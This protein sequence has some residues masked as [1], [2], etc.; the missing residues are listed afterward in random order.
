MMNALIESE[1]DAARS[2]RAIGGYL[3]RLIGQGPLFW[4]FCRYIIL[5]VPERGMKR[6]AMLWLAYE[7]GYPLDGLSL[8]D[9]LLICVNR[10]GAYR[11]TPSALA[12]LN[13]LHTDTGQFMFP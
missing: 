10:L 2:E 13:K 7:K 4:D 6:S 12:V 5:N 11:G 9:E 3:R 1:P 8:S